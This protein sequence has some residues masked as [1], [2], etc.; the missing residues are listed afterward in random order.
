MREWNVCGREGG[1]RK[2]SKVLE[3]KGKRVKEIV[4][5]NEGERKRE[6]SVRGE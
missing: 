2:E 3:V 4:R 5:G 6:W 1:V